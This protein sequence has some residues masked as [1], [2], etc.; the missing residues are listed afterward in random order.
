MHEASLARRLSPTQCEHLAALGIELLELRPLARA[1][2]A[3]TQAQSEDVPT[4][5]SYRLRVCVAQSSRQAPLLQSVIR[6]L[7]LRPEEIVHVDFP[8]LP[9]LA[10]APDIDQGV[11]APALEHLR[12]AS[13]K[14]ALW[15]A[16]RRLRRQL[17]S[18]NRAE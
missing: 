3:P 4:A 13:S 14:R 1:A 17:L 10:F 18:A 16:L 9:T 2:P 7:G 6:A 12:R 5:T 8:G 15:P 11:N